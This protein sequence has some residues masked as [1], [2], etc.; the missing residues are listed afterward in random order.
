MTFRFFNTTVGMFKRR[1]SMRSHKS[2]RSTSSA[3]VHASDK[4]P[5]PRPILTRLLK[6]KMASRPALA[7]G[8]IGTAP[9]GHSLSPT[10]RSRQWKFGEAMPGRKARDTHPSRSEMTRSNRFE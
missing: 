9:I 10:I 4:A 1:P 3:A 8:F 6:P 5:A 7:I 2:R